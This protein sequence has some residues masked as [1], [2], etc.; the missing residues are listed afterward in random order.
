VKNLLAF[1]LLLAFFSVSTA[2]AQSACLGAPAL[3]PPTGNLV[4]V[5]TVSALQSAVSN[6]S[7]GTT[8]MIAPGNF[9]LT[10]TLF[11]RKDNVTI[12]GEENNCDGT[13]LIGKGMEN[14]NFGNVPHGIWTD[15]AN[16]K[17]QNLTIRSVFHHPIQFSPNADSP[18]IYNVRLLDAGEQFIKGSSGGY[19]LGVDDGIVEYTILEYLT[20][21][22][23]IDHGGGIG[24]TNGVDIHGGQ[25]WIIRNNL[26]RNFHTPDSAR[27]IFNPAVLMWNGA[28]GTVTENNTFIDVDRA[29]AYGLID[30]GV[31]PDHRE[32][33]IR[34]NFVYQRPGLFSSTRRSQSDGLI[35]AWDSPN[36]QIVHNTILTNNNSTD[37][38]QF[39]WDTEGSQANNNLADEGIHSRNGARFTQTG[40]FLRATSS[41]FIAPGNANLHLKSTATAAIDKV[42]ILT[43][44]PRDIDGHMRPRGVRADI[45]ADEHGPSPPNNGTIPPTLIR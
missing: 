25:N 24:Y 10:K 36:T 1:L 5:S 14:T 40:N 8:I 17:V 26:F 28:Q 41:M 31:G 15:A 27:H 44:A 11:V 23:N 12:R 38:I 18:H 19:G 16:L 4:H 20:A 30:R 33:I 43:E 34:N 2:F 7:E 42:A 32:G 21:P 37:A 29:V 9:Q 39:R 35:I 22:P 13:T 45:G 6:V 3:P